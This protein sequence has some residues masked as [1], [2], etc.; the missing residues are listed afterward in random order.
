LGDIRA[1]GAMPQ[2]ALATIILPRASDAIQSDMLDEILSAAA[3]VLRRAGADLVG[4]HTSVGDDLTIGFSL[5]GLAPDRVIG[6]GGAQDGDALVLTRA[7]GSGTILAAHMALAAGG[8]DV[9]TCLALMETDQADAAAIL[10]PV[11]TA[12]TDVTGFGLAGHLM[13]ILRASGRAARIDLAAVPVMPGALALAAAGHASTLAPANR[14]ALAPDLVTP[15]GTDPARMALLFDP[16][17]AGGLLAC[18]PADRAEVTLAALRPHAPDAAII[19]RIGSGP[20]RL[21]LG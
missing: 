19:G 8:A 10:A 6:H 14:A 4:G 7:I 15:Q 2:A 11:A 20:P 1:M 17:T 12:M 18:V 5:T 9:A 3:A 21:H 16:Q 13:N